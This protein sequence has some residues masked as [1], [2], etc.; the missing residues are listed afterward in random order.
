MRHTLKVVGVGLMMTAAIVARP[1][2]AS[3]QVV[4]SLN[5]S[6]GAF[7]PRGEDTRV[8]GDVWLKDVQV[9]RM[10]VKDFTGGEVS[11]EWNFAFG[12]RVEVGLGGA[13]YQRTKDTSYRDYTNPNHSEIESTFKLRTLPVTGIVR[14]LPFGNAR[15][16]QPYVGA[17]VGVINWRYSEVGDFID[18]NDNNNVY[19]ARYTANGSKAGPV[20]LAG[21]R[22]P[23]G[24]DV[25]AFTFEG[26]YQRAEADLNTNDFLGSKLDLGG[27]SLRF[28][29]LLRF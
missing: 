29:V 25:W 18:F 21:F 14:L 6:L 11:G 2:T 15:S 27:T 23:V 20:F 22:A 3:A 12:D 10:E 13:F 1:A 8:T 17:G 4:Q 16:F 24:G 26:R 28:G 9:Y 7:L 19:H 5:L